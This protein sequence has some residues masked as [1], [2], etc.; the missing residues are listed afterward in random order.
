MSAPFARVL[1]ANRG[2]I[3][4]RII[5]TCRRLGIHSVAVYSEADA[6]A[7][8]VREADSAEYIGPPLA[9]E[10]YLNIDSILEAARRS[11]AEAVHPGY[12]FLS[13]NADFA[14]ACAGAG[15][16]FVGPS[17][18]AIRVMGDK[19]QAR[20]LMSEA[21]VPVI[22]GYDGTDGRADSI[23]KAVETIGYP[24]MVK[25]VAGGGG[26]GMRVVRGHAELTGALEAA[27]REAAAA[28][29]DGRIFIERLIEGGR[30][31]E[32]QIFGDNTGRV[33][34]L[35][36]RECSIQRRHQKVIEECPSAAVDD[37]L[38]SR[39]AEAA[40]KAG[41][42]V[43]YTNA[44]TV[45]F[46]LAPDRSFYFLEMN[47]RLQ[48]EHPVTEEVFGVDLVEWQLRIAADECLYQPASGQ[49]HAIEFRL[50]AEDPA[51]GFRP[52]PGLI[53]V[54]QVASGAR[55][56]GGYEAGDEVP[57]QYDSLL[58]KLIVSAGDRPAAV[59]AARGALGQM[60]IRGPSTNLQLLRWI[61]AH[62]EYA[63]GS[64][65]V[66]WLERVLEGPGMPFSPSGQLVATAAAWDLGRAYERLGAWRRL[67][68]RA[69][70]SYV[71]EGQA[72]ELWCETGRYGEWTIMSGEAKHRLSDLDLDGQMLSFRLDDGRVTAGVSPKSG[73]LEILLNGNLHAVE[74][75][76]LQRGA[77][78]PSAGATS[79][80][81][82]ISP[83]PGILVRVLVA[84]GDR[85][86]AGQPVAVLEAMK[87]E[88]QLNAPADGVVEAVM[89]AE[90]QRVEEG[91]IVLSLAPAGSGEEPG[92]DS[93]S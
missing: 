64:F 18:E 20:R 50:Y 73:Y 89:A 28:F 71:I 67:G 10:S 15:F 23:G 30:H 49:R 70:L 93:P 35:G 32:A 38:R 13:E 7:M 4:V 91:S 75:R 76:P 92:T 45:E 58:G 33:V 40:V 26:R 1:I 43:D 86:I 42:A 80:H 72:Y 2:E 44:G 29:G 68:G 25:A 66:T 69:L 24:L 36:E 62:P 34:F 53:E 12:G 87:M 61:A 57:P 27:S 46:L 31:I 47:T 84:K 59:R 6:G 56:D 54:L 19:V 37:E 39:L 22:P 85:V 63:D 17:P 8:H 14:E 11:G 9:A 65:D 51:H 90:G 60:L 16:V 79:W 88:H 78:G 77:G 21:G 52:S 5:K 83:M 48:V 74:R 3:A 82:V 41:E 55:W 81:S